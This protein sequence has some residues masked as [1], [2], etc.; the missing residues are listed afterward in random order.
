MI[1]V[2]I[3]LSD[4]THLLISGENTPLIRNLILDR[5]ICGITLFRWEDKDLYD[6]Y[7]KLEGP[8]TKTGVG[9]YFLGRRVLADL[10]GYSQMLYGIGELNND[11]V[12]IRWYDECLNGIEIEHRSPRDCGNLLYTHQSI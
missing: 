8:R 11:T 5:R 1:G 10:L 2:G 9:S 4:N 3:L 6:S 7:E 12:S